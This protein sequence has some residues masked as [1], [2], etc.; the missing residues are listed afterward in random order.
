MKREKK[1]TEYSELN[2]LV[3]RWF[4]DATARLVNV[5]MLQEKAMKFASD[6]GLGEFKGS[7]GWLEAFLIKRHNVV[8]KTQSGGGVRSRETL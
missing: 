4:L 6:L 7:N 3:F 8:F 1:E 2:S 5:S